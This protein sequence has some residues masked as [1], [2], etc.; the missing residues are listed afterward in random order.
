[1]VEFSEDL[2]RI[3][4]WYIYI[5]LAQ[6]VEI[7]NFPSTTGY[8]FTYSDFVNIYVLYSF[9][10]RVLGEDSEI[11]M[12]ILSPFENPNLITAPRE[13]LVVERRRVEE[14]VHII[15]PPPPKKT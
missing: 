7:L 4:Y 12:E 6:L 15:S 8:M 10:G 5:I 3:W 13:K 2:L 1:M 14:D 11:N 9:A